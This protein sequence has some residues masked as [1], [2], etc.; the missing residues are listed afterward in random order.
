MVALL[1]RLGRDHPYHTLY[2]V[3]G[4]KYGNRGKDGRVMAPAGNVG[5]GMSHTMDL[6]K[7]AAADAVLQRIGAH[8]DRCWLPDWLHGWVPKICSAFW[9]S[10]WPGFESASGYL[11][12]RGPWKCRK[13]AVEQVGLMIEAYIELAATPVDD[14]RFAVTTCP[15]RMATLKQD[16]FNDA[17]LIL[18]PSSAH[19][20]IVLGGSSEEEGNAVSQS[21]A[22]QCPG[23]GTGSH[24]E[25]HAGG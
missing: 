4:L 15:W 2:H 23:P 5:G 7:V 19:C 3:Y 6:D 8:T 22:A 10:F 13:E 14:V 9:K 12:R 11:A 24:R 16:T 18:W 1:E 21:A 25:C 20:A 17:A